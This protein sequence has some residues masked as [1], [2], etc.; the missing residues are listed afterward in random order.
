M[1]TRCQI[2]AAPILLPEEGTAKWELC[3]GGVV[4]PKGFKASGVSASLRSLG[5]RPDLSLVVSECD[6][7]AAGRET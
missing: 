7:A 6:A 2:E 1:V 4:A 5:V 3:N